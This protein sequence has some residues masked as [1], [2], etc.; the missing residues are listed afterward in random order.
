MVGSDVVLSF[1]GLTLKHSL[2]II[3]I[4]IQKFHLNQLS[5]FNLGVLVIDHHHL[6][7]DE[8][9]RHFIV[10]GFVKVQTN[11]PA[12][13]HKHIFDKT[14][15]IFERCWSFE[16][17]YNPLNN[18]LPMVH[19]LQEILDAPQVQGALTSILGNGYVLHPHRHCHPNFPSLPPTKSKALAMPL[20]KDGHATGK[21]PRHHL[22]RWA[23]LFYFPQ[24]CPIEIGPTCL[25]P[26]NQY[27][28]NISPEGFNTRSLIPALQQDGTFELPET[29][30]NRTLTTLEGELGDVWIMHFDIAHSVFF[31]HQ[32]LARYGMKFVYMRTEE[33]AAP[34]WNSTED[35]WHPPKN[36][37]V[38]EDYEILWTYVWN[39]LSGKSDLFATK[40]AS[41]EGNVQHWIKQ[42]S[43]SD[44]KKRLQAIK[45]LGFG[46][47]SS[48][49]AIPNLIGQLHEDYEPVRLNTA[50]ALA[51]I[52]ESAVQPLIERLTDG[53]ENYQA[54][55]ILHM[56]DAAH[57]LAAL[58]KPAVPALR[59]ALSDSEE[60]IRSQVVYALGEMSWR[61]ASAVSCLRNL[62]ADS[63]EPVKQHVISALGIIKQPLS[64][65]VPTLVRVL[66]EDDD[67][68]LSLFAAQ[69]LVRIGKN[70][71]SAIPAL[72]KALRSSSPYIRAFSIE[73]LSKI[74]T[75]EALQPL[76]A[77]LRTSRW[78]NYQG[79]RINVLDIPIEPTNFDLKNVD[80]VKSLVTSEFEN[81]Y[82]R[83]L[84]EIVHT[85]FEGSDCLRFLMA[86]GNEGFVE[87]KNN[88]LQCYY[89]RRITEGA[90]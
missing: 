22:P 3:L 79:S 37:W 24:K 55:P 58:G 66:E 54:E 70:A 42:L 23:I 73:A 53:R 18:I 52:G 16:R 78:F 50:Y 76:V 25:I 90:Y 75:Q 80:K 2:S 65:I 28:R 34:S 48:S 38:S 11:L 30:T 85:S 62:L 15:A 60:H 59:Q 40:R 6:L 82:K 41:T 69:A 89:L 29:F 1:L 7:T 57:S 31:N 43:D 32:D 35:H 45:E 71:K 17:R 86:D 67:P 8:Q 83:P 13:L 72:S 47:Q 20:H 46:H 19:E 39:W 36:N 21:R 49:V 12:Q 5:L 51:A 68:S 84:T 88:D 81:K 26:G 63:A 4:K 87:L 64:E 61:S 9:M 14:D 77:S 10:N 33:P 74:G 27:L 44:L 56:S